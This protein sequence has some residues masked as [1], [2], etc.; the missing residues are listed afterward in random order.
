MNDWLKTLLI[1]IFWANAAAQTTPR[2]VKDYVLEGGSNGQKEATWS[3][4]ETQMGTPKWGPANRQFVSRS[5]GLYVFG[6]IKVGELVRQC[7]SGVVVDEWVDFDLATPKAE[8]KIETQPN[9]QQ[10]KAETSDGEKLLKILTERLGQPAFAY[11]NA[12]VNGGIGNSVLSWK[13][14]NMAGKPLLWRLQTCYAND[15]QFLIGR[16]PFYARLQISSM[17]SVEDLLFS[18]NIFTMKA[19]EL[20]ERFSLAG[21]SIT[22]RKPTDLPGGLF[23]SR[24]TLE[25]VS[26]L[27]RL[28]SLEVKFQDDLKVNSI[29]M[30]RSRNEFMNKGYEVITQKLRSVPAEIK[31]GEKHFITVPQRLYDQSSGVYYVYTDNYTYTT[32]DYKLVWS[33]RNAPN[34]RLVGQSL[35]ILPPGL[36]ITRALDPSAF[37]LASSSEQGL[38]VE[39]PYFNLPVLD[40]SELK[41][42]LRPDTKGGLW[43]D[44]PMENQGELPF[45]FPASMARILRYYGRQV[46]QFAVATAGGVDMRGTDWPKLVTMLDQCCSK[47]GMYTRKMKKAENF[48]AFV[49]ESIDNGQLILWL[50]PGHARIINGYNLRTGTIY[51]T[52]SWGEGFER[53][54]M[55]YTEAASMTNHAYVFLPPTAVK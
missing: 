39:L 46:N 3:R 24:A 22:E 15:N 28:Q 27:G 33:P 55:P 32:E 52:D 43:L 5:K 19:E 53:V 26:T 9:E 4:D 49:K 13:A 6:N 18:R 47:F 25:I 17:L 35:Q 23:G 48:G 50:I 16:Q 1:I 51:Y 21:L 12:S 8:P 31:K 7:Q 10:N 30:R 45:C 29:V 41:T 36:E 14:L 20:L 11:D 54:S 42:N 40:F 34:Y 38:G 37:R 44:I 2:D